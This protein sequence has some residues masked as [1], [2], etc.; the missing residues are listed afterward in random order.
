MTDLNSQEHRKKERIGLFGGTFN[1][2][3]SGHLKAAKVVQRACT[4]QKILFIPSFIPPHKGSD[5]VVSA[6]HRLSMVELAI[7]G[8]PGFIAS[9]IEIEEGG[10]SYS[11]LTLFKI[12]KIYPVAHFFFILGVDAFLEIE[13][14]KDYK[15]LL[16]QC[17][18]I[19]ISRRGYRLQEARTV[20]GKEY[21]ARMFDLSDG[22]FVETG[23]T[24]GHKIFLLPFDAIDVSSTVLRKRLGK[25][26]SIEG[27][28]PSSVEKYIQ[29]NKLYQ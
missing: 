14:W 3:H 16:D 15:S 13:T 19:V 7:E 29:R 9:D 5:K 22:G 28:V 21:S 4:L 23:L 12:I 1:P 11:I 6:A 2:I 25:Q 24:N 17:S 8:N 20:L 27:L 26:L 10:K 18:F